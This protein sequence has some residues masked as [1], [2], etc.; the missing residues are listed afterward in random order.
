MWSKRCTT[1]TWI[2]IF[3]KPQFA[4][5]D[6]RYKVQK[7]KK[8]PCGDID[9]HHQGGAIEH[10]SPKRVKYQDSNTRQYAMPH[11]YCPVK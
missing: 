2:Y 11:Q 5:I 10:I 7:Y 3:K 9:K 8:A 1:P 6:K 4:V